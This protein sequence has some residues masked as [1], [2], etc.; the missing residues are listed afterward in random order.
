MIQAI[1]ADRIFDGD[2]S[3]GPG[4]VLVENGA[5]AAVERANVAPPPAAQVTDL[6]DVTLLPGLIDCHVHLGFACCATGEETVERMK[7]DDDSVLLLRMRTAAQRALSAGVT[8]LRDLGDRSFLALRLREWF[9]GS[10]EVGPH[11]VSSGPPITSPRGHCWFMGG[12][13]EG[14]EGMREAV[15]RRHERGADVIKIM[16][17]GGRMTTGS[18]ELVTQFSPDE[19]RAAVEEAN[20][21]GLPVTAHAHGGDGV[22]MAVAAGVNGIEHGG[23]WTRDGAYATDEDLDRVVESGVAYSLTLGMTEGPPPPADILSRLEGSNAIRKRL[24]A[25]GARIVVGSDAGIVSRKPH[26]VMPRGVAQLCDIGLTPLEALTSATKLAAEVCG[27]HDS[28]GRIK[29]GHDADL[30]AVGGDPTVDPKSLLDVRA[31]FRAGSRVV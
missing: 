20:R 7:Q 16:A 4:W 18:D 28:K 1:S 30:L 12:E 21:L 31:V 10:D 23:F 3:R 19:L 27:L 24:A 5:I 26:D 22:R 17:T 9:A 8:T 6:G 15:R 2:R 29:A 25:R 11:I 14:V 13:A